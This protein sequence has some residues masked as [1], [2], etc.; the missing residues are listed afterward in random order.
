MKAKV[1]FNTWF[2]RIVG[3]LGY[4]AITLAWFIFPA[5]GKVSIS[6]RL[7][8][9]ECIHVRQ[10]AEMF[11]LLQWLWYGVEYLIRLA[12][13]RNHDKAYRNT[14]FEREAYANEL[15]RDYLRTRKCWAWF[16]YL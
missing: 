5:Y 13:Y 4:G 3:K 12:Y 14:S 2:S 8:N 7:F 6:D 16:K 9:H 10:Q 11:Y 1:K 15:N